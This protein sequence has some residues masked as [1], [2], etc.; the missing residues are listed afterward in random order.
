MAA[1]TTALIA[2]GASLGAA[3]ISSDAAKKSA[4]ATESAVQSS[5]D[6][7][8]RIYQQQRADQEPWRVIGQ[9]ALEQ[10]GKLYGFSSTGQKTTPDM[11]SFTASPDYQFRVDEGVKALNS[12]YAARGALQSG[13]AQKA[14][15]NYGQQAASQEFGNYFN[16]LA[17][18]AGYGSSANQANAQSGQNYADATGRNNL[19]AADAKGSSYA[20]Q[21]NATNQALGSLTGVLARVVNKPKTTVSMDNQP[22]KT[23]L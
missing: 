6:T 13:A 2:G 1:L 10:M 12:G 8:E 9:Q 5:N 3:K 19:I 17:T 16:R 20:S 14:I 22:Q 21:A 11:S 23:W 15:L 7:Q 18:M 4:K